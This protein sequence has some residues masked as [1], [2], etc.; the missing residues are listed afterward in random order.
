M[1]GL[2][3]DSSCQLCCK[4][5]LQLFHSTL[6]RHVKFLL[7]GCCCVAAGPNALRGRFSRLLPGLKRS[8]CP[9]PRYKLGTAHGDG[10]RLHRRCLSSSLRHPVEDDGEVL[11]VCVDSHNMMKDKE[12]FQVEEYAAAATASISKK[13][14]EDN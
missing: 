8:A 9:S 4:F 5:C 10:G 2:S 12:G 1:P 14:G 6:Q 7:D 11:D 13:T 3:G